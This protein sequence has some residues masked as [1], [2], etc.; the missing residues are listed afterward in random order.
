MRGTIE[1]IGG[2]IGWVAA[3]ALLVVGAVLATPKTLRVVSVTPTGDDVLPGR[4]V[5]VQFDRAMVALG[6]MAREA[7]EVPVTVEPDP[8]CEWRWLDPSSLACHLGEDQPLRP[9]TRYRLRVSGDAEA[10]DGSQLDEAVEHTWLTRRPKVEDWTFLIWNGPTEPAVQIDLDQVVAL[11]ELERRLLYVGPDDAHYRVRVQATERVHPERQ[12]KRFTVTPAGPLPAD[13]VVRL[14]AQAG[15]RSLE[16]PEPSPADH[17]ILAMRTFPAPRFL[18]VVCRDPALQ[19]RRIDVG[20]TGDCSPDRPAEL[21]FSSPMTREG[22]RSHLKIEPAP[23]TGEGESARD[24]WDGVWIPST[25]RWRRTVAP[26][27]EYQVRLPGVAADQSIHLAAPNQLTDAFGR[28]L[29]V[30]VDFHFR[31]G[32]HAPRAVLTHPVSVLE[33][34]VPTHVPATVTN[35][36]GMVV[37]GHMLR[38]DGRTPLDVEMQVVPAHNVRYA[39]P[40]K[41]RDWLGGRSGAVLATATPTPV[42]PFSDRR[43]FLSQVTPFAVH[44]KLGHRDSLVWVTDMTTGKPVADASVTVQSVTRLGLDEAPKS[45]AE[46][47]TDQDGVARLPGNAELDPKLDAARWLRMPEHDPILMVRVVKGDDLALLL[48]TRQ[49]EVDARGPANSWM[50]AWNRTRYGHIATWGATAQGVYRPGST[51]DYK[52]WVRDRDGRRLTGPPTGPW[53]LEVFDPHDKVVLSIDDLELDRFGAAHGKLPLPDN[54]A[55]GWYRF[56]LTF[57]DEDR[58]DEQWEPL[59]VLVA[60]FT[61]SPFRATVTLDGRRFRAG[62][63]AGVR[64]EARLH[65]GGPYGRAAV[66]VHAAVTAARLPS[67][68]PAVQGYDFDTAGGRQVVLQQD[69]ELDEAGDIEVRVDLGRAQ[70]V[71]GTLEIE[72]AVRDDR[73][74]SV[75]AR[76]RAPFFGRDRFVGVRQPDWLLT[77]GEPAEALALVLDDR[78]ALADDTDITVTVERRV[79]RAARVKGA[80]NVYET[81][82][83]ESWESVASCTG[84]PV[85]REPFRCTFT[86]TGG[87]S[88]RLRA[89]IRDTAGREHT[90]ETWR[91][92][93]GRGGS[94]WNDDPGLTLPVEP[95]KTEYKVGETARILVRNPF[96][97]GQAL[98]TTERL[99]VQKAWSR[100]LE[101]SSEII[102]IPIEPEH[103]PGFYV[104]VVVTSPRVEAAPSERGGSVHDVDLG[105]PAMRMGY[106]RLPVI[107][108]WKELEVTAVPEH[109]QYRPRETVRV[110]L[111]AEPKHAAED[112]TREPIQVAVVVLDEAVFDLVPGGREAYD[113]YRGLYD[114]EPLDVHNFNLLTRLVGLQNFEEKGADPGGGGGDS[115]LRTRFDFVAHWAPAVEL[116][117]EGNGSIEFEVPDNLTGFRVLA[118]AATP[119]DRL[120]LGEG[121]FA[122][123]RPIELRPALPNHVVEGDVF[124]A[125]FTVMNR[126]DE[127]RRLT[128]TAKADGPATTPGLD[129]LIVDA[130]PY[131]RVP[132]VFP[133]TAHSAGRLVV[134]VR[135]D[136]GGEQD[137]LRV[138]LEILP[139]AVLETAAS[140]GST[141]GDGAREALEIPS[142]IRPGVSRV[143][144]TLAPTILGNLQGAVEA[145]RDYP[146]GCW[147]QRLS[148]AVMAAQYAALRDH[149]PADL[150]WPDHAAV[151]ADALKQAASY[152]TPSGA[153]AFYVADDRWASPYL[154][155]YTA[156]AFGW[157]RDLGHRPP[158]PVEDALHRYLA[159]LL[160]ND[161]PFPDYYSRGMASSVRAVTLAA[162]ARS[163]VI[164]ADDIARHA[165]HVESMDLFGKAHFLIAAQT[166]GHDAAALVRD[167]LLSDTDRSAGTFTLLERITAADHR[168]LAS[169][170]RSQCAALSALVRSRDPKDL[171]ATGDLM[172]SLAR[173][174]VTERGRRD[175]WSNTQ[176]NLFC[177]Q[178]LLDYARTYEAATVDLKA[179]AW[180]E[181]ADG[182]RADR[183]GKARFTRA[184]DPAARL[185]RPLTADQAGRSLTLEVARKG[186]GRLYHTMRLVWAPVEPPTE[187]ANAG[188]EV[189][190]EISVQRAGAWQLLG[191]EAELTRGEIVRV[192]LFV[193]LPAN[194]EFVVVEDP[195]A[196]GLEPVDRDLETASRVDAAAGNVPWAGGSHWWSRDH[197]IGFA[198]SHWSFYHR[199]LGHDAVRFYSEHLPAGHYHLAYVAQVVADGTF[200]V[201]PPR[202]EAMYDPDVFGRGT[203]AKIIVGGSPP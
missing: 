36:S 4:Q 179:R 28:P 29:E 104:S 176:E 187:P 166:I 124:D 95:E 112:G 170:P 31:Y 54:A 158:A 193:S 141:I 102:E 175:R 10:L 167:R 164:S 85:G 133:I 34:G 61:P 143:E 78:D 87:G 13:T 56:E 178:A 130:P 63:V 200:R 160:R 3:L 140:H 202:A 168:I 6:V 42:S 68:N 121:T 198:G 194:R 119:T 169:T 50:P 195:V 107:D 12:G 72:S 93:L 47:E 86:P 159:D 177:T 118:M 99:G 148:R 80:G 137:G 81:R 83:T 64:T 153:M 181:P 188:I 16:G 157:L 2:K 37:E 89:T 22:L 98:I 129:G 165:Q 46:A 103:V 97:G 172:P 30:P 96:P 106:V 58:S 115:T 94:S 1:R 88:H 186:S 151:L 20:N 139:A 18:G 7:D 92:A 33:H 49:M 19:E 24:P 74:K 190:R 147:E 182:G 90:S 136:G 110:A 84:R 111:H 185:E 174:I 60:D 114:F 180:I 59:R 156:L 191:S 184:T 41:V 65:A 25:L 142:D 14:V 26:G 125:R 131:E 17:E 116:D 11:A 117:A 44:A 69:G 189:R 55:M 132:I 5:V 150:T 43:W 39:V 123:D 73:G 100:V 62:D 71:Y 48:L 134:T 51:V 113:P 108:P 52:L 183:L 128:I 35:V 105:K 45:L 155:A 32:D 66:R 8:G 171:G 192:D 138:P 161:D 145:L 77:S 101:S 40:L 135:A 91:W 152:Q 57:A 70:A 203:P 53:A 196:G 163:S 146:Y 149:L 197:W 38:A 126:T 199:E 75:A 21:R 127:P 9:A 67:K 144:L 201:L 82:T 122:V 27:V 162:L 120:G 79:V 154:S 109:A 15:M 23:A 173:T 76:T